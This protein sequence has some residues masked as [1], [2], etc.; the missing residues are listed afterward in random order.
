MFLQDEGGCE[1]NFGYWDFSQYNHLVKQVE[2]CSD[3]LREV[4]TGIEPHVH[5]CRIAKR[6]LKHLQTATVDLD[7]RAIRMLAL[8]DGAARQMVKDG[9]TYDKRRDL[10]KP[11]TVN[12][13][14]SKARPRLKAARGQ[15]KKKKAAKP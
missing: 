15:N 4:A 11:Q 14:R 10:F 7:K 6:L 3:V 12:V 5:S 1:V 2:K 13:E 8:Y 9:V